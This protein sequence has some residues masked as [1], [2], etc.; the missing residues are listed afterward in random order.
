MLFGGTVSHCPVFDRLF[1]RQIP[2]ISPPHEGQRTEKNEGDQAAQQ[3]EPVHG[4]TLLR[5]AEPAA[6]LP[7]FPARSHA[8]AGADLAPVG[9][10]SI[11]FISCGKGKWKS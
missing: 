1:G 5:R 2:A 4:A 3:H 7:A 11:T 9:A 10:R 6:A 8:A